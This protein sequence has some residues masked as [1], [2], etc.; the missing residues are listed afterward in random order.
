MG[1][2]KQVA[3]QKDFFQLRGACVTNY[4]NTPGT[5]VAGCY[6]LAFLDGSF[7]I[8]NKKVTIDLPYETRDSINR[9]VAPDFK[10]GAVLVPVLSAG[11][12]IAAS[13]QAVVSTSDLSQYINEWN[14]YFIGG[15]V[16]LGAGTPSADPE[17]VTYNSTATLSGGNFTGTV[18]GLT[19]TKNTV[20]VRAC[21]A[22][23]CSYTQITP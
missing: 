21:S 12:S 13:F 4:F 9:I 14:Q 1:H 22:L 23:E 15:V 20:F 3:A 11:M 5:A 8:A 18:G 2:I 19:T 10:P 6:H 16:Q 17:S 7:D